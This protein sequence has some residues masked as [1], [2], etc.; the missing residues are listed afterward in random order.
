IEPLSGI[1]NL[2]S[3]EGGVIDSIF[4]NEGDSLRK[5]EVILTFNTQQE[6]IQMQHLSLQ[7]ATQKQRIASD[8]ANEQQYE[9][10]LK[11]KTAT[12]KV[13]ESLA[14]SGA[15]TRQQVE[16]L[17][18]DLEVLHANLEAAQKSTEADRLII[19]EL[20]NQIQQL[21]SSISDKSIIAPN[22]G[23]LLSLNARIG[24][25]TEAYV[26]LGEFAMNEPLVI[27]GEIDEL[28]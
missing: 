5:G 1:V 19:R 7:I 25:A 20:E 28:F 10:A 14:Q 12:L 18:K 8:Q 4:K 6:S 24:Q 9:A 3:N 15:E 23:I 22:D 16:T 21:R 11:E 27:H 2:G 13:S 17:R 26:T